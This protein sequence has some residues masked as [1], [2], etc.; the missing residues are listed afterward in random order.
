MEIINY[1]GIIP[2]IVIGALIVADLIHISKLRLIYLK[3]KHPTAGKK[4][5]ETAR[6]SFKKIL[7][8][9]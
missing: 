6:E 8:Q 5:L 4:E 9:K 7:E 2:S 1:I 3:F